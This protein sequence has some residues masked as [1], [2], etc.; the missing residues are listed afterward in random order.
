MTAAVRPLAT[1][2]GA[3]SY[4]TVTWVQGVPDEDNPGEYLPGDPYD[5]TGCTARMQIRPTTISTDVWVTATTEND[6]ITLGGVDG[7]ITVDIPAE[8]TDKIVAKKGAYDIEVE[9][10]DGRVVRVM[11]GV[12]NNS[13]S[14]TRD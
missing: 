14:V 1:E 12:V 3:T 4:F 10:P 13:L 9:F 2:Q 5:L 7:T 11:Q 8:E 6:M